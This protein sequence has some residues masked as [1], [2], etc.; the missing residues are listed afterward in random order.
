MQ[1]LL[2][3]AVVLT[4]IAVLL[5][6]GYGIYA[7]RLMP[8]SPNRSSL[9]LA[10]LNLLEPSVTMSILLVVGMATNTFNSSETVPLLLLAALPLTALLLAPLLAR[11][12]SPLQRVVAVYGCLRWLNTVALWVGGLL[13]D[14]SNPDETRVALIVALIVSGILILM[15]SVVQIGSSLETT[16]TQITQ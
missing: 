2:V 12:K 6:F 1:E 9:R 15:L 5:G 14:N 4:A 7:L 16:K 3:L 8:A 10:A 11:V 13:G